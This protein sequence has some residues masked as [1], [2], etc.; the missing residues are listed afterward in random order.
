M[1]KALPTV[2]VLKSFRAGDNAQA[3]AL[4]QR[5]GGTIVEKQ[6]AFNRLAALPNVVTG[7]SIRMLTDVARAQ[8]QP[9]WPDLLIATGRRTAAV[10]LWIKRHSA[11]KTK[12]IQLGRPRLPLHLFDLVVTTPQYGLPSGR[13][14]VQLPLPIVAV[15]KDAAEHFL[16]QWRH[17][18]KPWIVAVVGGQKFPLRMGRLELGAFGTAIDQFA[19]SRSASVILLSSPR[20]PKNALSIVAEKITQL[21]W[22]ASSGQPNAYGAT[23]AA[24]DVFCVTSDSVSMVA[25]MLATEK[26]VMVF[27]LP[28]SPLMMHWD[29]GTGVFAALARNGI[30]SPPRNTAAMMRQLIDQGIVGD[31]LV[32]TAPV[33]AHAI[34]IHQQEVVQRVRSLVGL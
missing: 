11:G 3:M 19:K 28:V 22:L 16:D 10:A 6:M 9:P 30:L 1:A 14:I 32:G 27:E 4:A 7:P 21:K 17:L 31:L 26:P 33:A 8:L 34:T 13:N 12:I 23:L 15:R 24:G 25:E 2:W 18:P 29:A 20:S 5:V